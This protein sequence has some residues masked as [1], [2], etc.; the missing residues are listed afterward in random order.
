MIENVEKSIATRIDRRLLTEQL[1]TRER[2]VSKV[3][4]TQ[5]RYGFKLK[6]QTKAGRTNKRRRRRASSLLL[7]QP[8]QINRQSYSLHVA[9]QIV[10]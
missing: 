5:G 6:K 1:N 8:C 7:W 3:T 2:L 9:P 10:E 4:N